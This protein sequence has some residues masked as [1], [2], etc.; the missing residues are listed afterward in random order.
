[1]TTVLAIGDIHVYV[2]DLQAALRFWATGL[3]LEVAEQDPNQYGAYARLEFP[4]GG[5]SLVLMG[6][7]EPPLRP[8]QEADVEPAE[9]AVTFEIMTTAFDD[10]LVRLLE[11]GGQQLGETEMYNDLKIATVSDPDGNT[12]ELIELPPDVD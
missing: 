4:D 9:P 3:R 6:G 5:P 12:F 8:T 10:I 7:D 2:T 11:H 1:M